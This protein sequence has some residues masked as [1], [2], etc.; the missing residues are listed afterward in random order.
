MEQDNREVLTQGARHDQQAYLDVDY[1]HKRR[2]RGLKRGRM[3]QLERKIAKDANHPAC[4][5]CKSPKHEYWQH[6]TKK[7]KSTT[8]INDLPYEILKLILNSTLDLL[9]LACAKAQIADWDA[10]DALLVDVSGQ[11]YDLMTVNKTWADIVLE[12]V[13]I[14]ANEREYAR[15][16]QK[17]VATPSWTMLNPDMR[18]RVHI[19]L[20]RKRIDYQDANDNYPIIYENGKGPACVYKDVPELMIVDGMLVVSSRGEGRAAITSAQG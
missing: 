1:A 3:N 18:H 20:H 10:G 17:K 16:T 9:V 15:L 8:T 7:T 11:V 14:Q 2:R 13:L 6:V 5:I 4:T 12:D 19:G